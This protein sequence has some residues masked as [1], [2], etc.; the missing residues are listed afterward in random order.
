ML[1]WRLMFTFDAVS[2]DSN[3]PGQM[4]TEKKKQTSKFN[5]L[6]NIIEPLMMMLATACNKYQNICI[7]GKADWLSSSQAIICN[8]STA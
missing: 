7:V 8:I 6:F 5:F 4:K 1:F 2:Q 3:N